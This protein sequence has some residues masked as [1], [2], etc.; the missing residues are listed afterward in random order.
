MIKKL[1]FALSCVT[2]FFATGALAQDTNLEKLGGFKTTGTPM[3]VPI[4]QAGE[5]VEALKAIAAQIKVP[6]GFS[7]SLY[8]AVPDARHMAVGPQGV[9]TFVGTRKELVYSMT[10][11]NKDRVADD[12]KVFAPSI[13]MAVPNGV[14]FS[15]DGHLYLAEQ[16][17][18]L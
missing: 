3:M 4:P 9:V 18:V 12:V 16:N 2:A 11:R 10:D 8:A 14:C 13:K 5:N 17:R 1:M 15:R 7:V 6:A